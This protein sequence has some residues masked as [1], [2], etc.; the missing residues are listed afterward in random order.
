MYFLEVISEVAEFSILL[1]ILE[2]QYQAVNGLFGLIE[3]KQLS[4]FWFFP[5]VNLIHIVLQLI[6]LLLIHFIEI[7]H[8]FYLIIAVLFIQ[9]QW[10]D[11]KKKAIDLLL[12]EVELFAHLM[13]LNADSFLLLV[14]FFLPAE[15][16][17][18]LQAIDLML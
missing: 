10:F 17:L 1:S 14:L 16:V 7:I 18:T 4:A 11:L 12:F 5:K 2:K 3:L 9:L 13:D 15:Q 8:V 6:N